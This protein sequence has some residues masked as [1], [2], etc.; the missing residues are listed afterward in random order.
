MALT[1]YA[2][3]K[4]AIDT[5]LNRDDLAA[6]AAA[7]F[8][9]LA[10]ASMQR[11]LTHWRGETTTSITIDGRFEDVPTDF[12]APIR[13][14]VGTTE[15][16]LQLISVQDLHDRRDARDDDTGTPCFYAIVGGQFEFLP[17]PTASTTGTLLYRASIP[18]LSDENTSNWV[19]ANAPDVY[20]YGAL[21]HSAP[22]LVEDARVATWGA[23]YAQA[24]AQFNKQ[25]EAGKF[26]GAGKRRRVRK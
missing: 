7:D 20:L 11:D 17:T 5:F 4:T 13:F 1:T 23:L 14:E 18:A 19:L 2:E 16:P 22:Y 24:V 9:T 21:V 25:G 6:T 10:E 26:G 15:A 8:I 3:L 12:I